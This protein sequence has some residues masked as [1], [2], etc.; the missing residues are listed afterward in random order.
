M[1]I[2]TRSSK[3]E[4]SFSPLIS[5]IVPVY[6][7]EKTLRQCV[8]S[9]L[10]QVFKDFE[11]LLIDDGSIDESPSICDEYAL[12]DSRVRVFHK[13][14]GGVSSARNLG[15][16]HCKG[17]WVTFIDSD[18]FITKDFFKGVVDCHEDLLINQY[19]WLDNWKQTLDKR[20][21]DYD[22]ISGNE[23]ICSFLNKYLTTLIFRGPCAKFY[24]K[25]ILNNIRFNEN[26]KVG[27]D[28]CFVHAYLLNCNSFR[29]LHHGQYVVR[30][31]TVSADVKYN[32]FTQ[33]AIESLSKVYDTFCQIETKWHLNKRLFISYLA[34]FKMISKDDWK[35]K[36]SKWYRNKDVKCFYDYVWA[37]LSVKQK[38]KYKLIQYISLFG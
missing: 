34:Y 28:T 21:S 37:Y 14:N 31:A 5:V 8:D 3:P 36:P 19:V 13:S 32:C 20:I 29:C 22:I 9:V 11:L 2:E 15:L 18:D 26:M 30:L 27:E 35:K 10:S 16:D 7:A 6:N 38:I 24:K 1:K 17:E 23:S 4:T 33:Y 25:S 12:N